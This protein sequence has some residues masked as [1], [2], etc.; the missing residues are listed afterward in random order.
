MFYSSEI[1]WFFVG[2]P[3]RTIVEWFA[4]S[5][6]GR[7]EEPRTDEYLLLP[8]CTTVGVKV[9]EGRFEVKAQTSQR[10]PAQYGNGV[11]GYEESWIKW[12][13]G[14]DGGNDAWLEGEDTWISVIKRRILRL[15]AIDG[16]QV[17]EVP[18]GQFI[19]GAGCQLELAQLTVPS[20]GLAPEARWWSICLEAFG[21]SGQTQDI[22]AVMAAHESLGDIAEVLTLEASMSY[23]LWLARLSTE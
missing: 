20:P 16:E 9:R 4:A 10:E 22:L 19:D 18:V 2:E 13:H 6:L 7:K 8:G 17:D 5:R 14:L 12:S 15:Y 21:S 11:R 3:N 23:P 1:R